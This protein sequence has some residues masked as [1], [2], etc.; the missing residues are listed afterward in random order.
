MRLA[1]RM[2]ES[3][4]QVRAGQWRRHAGL[5]LRGLTLG[6]GLGATEPSSV[7]S[8]SLHGRSGWIGG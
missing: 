8:A 5:E 7:V 2:T 6:V 3:D 1:H 4:R